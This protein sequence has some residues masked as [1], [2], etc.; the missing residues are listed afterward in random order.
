MKVYRVILE[1]DGK[2]TR[3]PGEISTEILRTEIYYA[4]E[5]IDQVW[6]AVNKRLLNT[7][8]IFAIIEEHPTIIILEASPLQPP[9]S[10]QAMEARV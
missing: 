4:A 8:T 6:D 1:H 10:G 3:N 2:T 7:Q 9:E 5:E